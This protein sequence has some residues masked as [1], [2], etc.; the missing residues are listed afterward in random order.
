MCCTDNLFRDLRSNVKRF[1]IGRAPEVLISFLATR[2]ILKLLLLRSG[3]ERFSGELR[4]SLGESEWD[5]GSGI[6]DAE[7][8]D[9]SPALGVEQCGDV[10][11]G[12]S[13]ALG[14]W[15]DGWD[16]KEWELDGKGPALASGPR[17]GPW[18]FHL[19]CGREGKSAS[20]LTS[21]FAKILYFSHFRRMRSKFSSLCRSS[22]VTG[23]ENM[24]FSWPSIS[25]G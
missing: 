14:V 18:G 21:C 8:G 25:C 17:G 24:W 20:A 9:A 6:R 22:F 13:H 19:S 23:Q 12:A 1:A 3:D 15:W 7:W 5:S 11:V 16:G 10:S 4:G 2:T